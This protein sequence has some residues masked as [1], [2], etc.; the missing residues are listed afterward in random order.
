V[1]IFERNPLP[2][3]PL[4]TREELNAW[5]AANHSTH[6]GF[7]LVS[8]RPGP[9]IPYDDLVEECLIWGWIDS[10][11]Q[12]F[13]EQTHGIR[14]TPRKPNS[15]WSAINKVRLAKLEAAGMMQPPGIAAVEIAKANGMYTFLDDVDAMI[16]P[17]DLAEALGEDL[18]TFEGFSPGRIKQ[19]LYWVKSAKRPQTRADRIAKV[20]EAARDGRSLF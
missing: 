1:P 18:A 7:W 11:V 10:T 15:V 17:E 2:R 5:F 8:Q 19:A 14:L 20:A 9:D 13:D 3:I 16:V 12:T 6:K 4:G